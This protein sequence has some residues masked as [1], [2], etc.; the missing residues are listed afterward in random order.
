LAVG[1]PRAL[2]TGQGRTR[3]G[4]DAREGTREGKDVRK[5]K[6]RTVSALG[7]GEK[8]ASRVYR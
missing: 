2:F 3:G 8:D 6:E 7:N 5:T 4:A 1:R